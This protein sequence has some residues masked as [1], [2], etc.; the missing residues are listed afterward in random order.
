V[1]RIP[2]EEKEIAFFGALVSVQVADPVTSTPLA[3]ALVPA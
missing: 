3:Q 1:L 2:V